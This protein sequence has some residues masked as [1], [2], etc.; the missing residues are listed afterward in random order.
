M[1]QPWLAATAWLVAALVAC[2]DPVIQMELALPDVAP[3][4]FD[5]SCVGAVKIDVIGNAP[6]DTGDTEVVSNCFDFERP[7]RDFSEVAAGLRGQFVFDIPRGGL[8]GVQLS[9]FSGRCTDPNTR[10]ESVF[11]GGAPSAGDGTLVI[12]LRLGVACGTQQSYQVKTIDLTSLYLPSGAACALPS[13]PVRLF[14]GVI[15]PRMLGPKAP[16][17]VFEYGAD[18][19]DTGDGTG[20][21]QS[22]LPVPGDAACV[23]LGYRG[24]ASLGLTCIRPPAQARGLCGDTNEI[25]IISLPVTSAITAVDP[26]L[27][28]A[29]GDPVIG[30]VWDAS[31]RQPIAGATAALVDPT[32][33]K[34]VYTDLGLEPGASPSRL[35][36]MTQVA[37]ATSTIA[38]GGFMAYL[39]G[40]ATDLVVTAPNHVPE[41]LRVASAPDQLPTLVVVLARQ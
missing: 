19:V 27:T 26:A 11:Y 34:V 16:R 40:E 41:L 5:V 28:A 25:E 32:Q 17:T 20:R 4:G 1:R 23:A 30:T 35:R 6:G 37:G 7:V 33:G 24:T 13:D 3:A 29:Y 12:P 22:F 38:G 14:A 31:T 36:P 18:S 21:V 10:Y 2:S 8:A 39:R 15:R 9:G